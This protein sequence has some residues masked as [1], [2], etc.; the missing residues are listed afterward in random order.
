MLGEIALARGD[1]RLA[2]Q[3]FSL[4]CRTNPK[5]VGGL[6]LR[7]Y[8]AWKRGDPAQ[9]RELLK[10]ARAARGKEWKPQG[11]VMEGDVQRRMHVDGTLFSR[12][13]DSWDGTLEPAQALARLD[14][15][16]HRR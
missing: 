16:L 9:A 1:L 7:A 2:D 5:A 11:S 12:V 13:W 15:Q 10:S 8:I 14:T 6:Y 4:A 3:R